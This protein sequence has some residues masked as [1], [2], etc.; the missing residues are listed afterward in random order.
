MDL[1]QLLLSSLLFLNHTFVCCFLLAQH[2]RPYFS[3]FVRHDKSESVYDWTF[4]S[5]I[6]V[7]CCPTG[8]KIEAEIWITSLY[9]NRALTDNK[10]WL[11]VEH[12]DFRETLMGG[13]GKD[14]ILGSDSPDSES[15]PN[16]K[17]YP[18]AAN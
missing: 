3:G 10:P 12:E 18:L 8:M 7:T 1:S 11:T 6:L 9:F 17:G 16:M 14:F 2:S 5:V 4:S 15:P 13:A